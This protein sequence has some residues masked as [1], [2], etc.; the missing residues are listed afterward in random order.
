M[1][2][3]EASV[4]NLHSELAVM[5]SQ[6]ELAR[7]ERDDFHREL[8]EA[9]HTVQKLRQRVRHVIITTLLSAYGTIYP[10]IEYVFLLFC[11][12][13]FLGYATV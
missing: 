10:L 2:D 9:R 3:L 7:A 1:H 13:F 5:A 6:L 4:S 8:S 12:F 11:V